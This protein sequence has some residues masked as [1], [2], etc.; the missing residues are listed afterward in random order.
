MQ[1]QLLPVF[2]LLTILDVTYTLVR[3]DGSDCDMVSMPAGCSCWERHGLQISCHSLRLFSVPN[4]CE[5][6]P[7]TLHTV[8]ITGNDID[9]LSTSELSLCAINR[10]TLSKNSLMYIEPLAFFSS[11]SS[12]TSLDLSHN[13]LNAVPEAVS[14]LV[15][16]K[17]LNLEDNIIFE[18]DL[19][20]ISTGGLLLHSLLLAINPIF[21]MV[22]SEINAA[23][24]IKM[25]SYTKD[26]YS[27]SWLPE[28][29]PLSLLDG[30]STLVIRDTSLATPVILSEHC[31]FL[32]HLSIDSSQLKQND[33]DHRQMFSSMQRNMLTTLSLKHNK[34]TKF[35]RFMFHGGMYSLLMLDLS[36]NQIK[37]LR[38]SH[39]S[40]LPVLETLNIRN[41]HIKTIISNNVISPSL[42]VL[43]LRENMLQ[44]LE[45]RMFYAED[46][47]HMTILMGGN[48]LD[49]SCQF[50]WMWELIYREMEEGEGPFNPFDMWSDMTC[51]SPYGV[52]GHNVTS[53]APLLQTCHEGLVVN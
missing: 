49:C 20:F 46:L 52:S 7:L 31:S 33:V 28:D 43:D 50:S 41:N 4:L 5:R 48:P 21:S 13:F 1:A 32:H 11:A 2:F 40:Y 27:M 38:Q 12:L 29:I 18:V 16:L 45:S 10:L 17:Y 26:E 19:D 42:T 51:S 24:E 44:G 14:S 8:D 34:L 22:S 25:L 23:T 35:P 9:T 53:V 15:N 6:S 30:L 36:Y 3:R 47:D 37:K 39:M